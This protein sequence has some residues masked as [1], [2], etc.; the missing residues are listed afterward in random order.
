V[1]KPACERLVRVLD[2]V[3]SSLAGAARE[4][5]LCYVRRCGAG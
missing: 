5:V 3:I 1:G 2:E 4:R